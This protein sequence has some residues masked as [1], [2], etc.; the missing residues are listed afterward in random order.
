MVFDVFGTLVD[1]RRSIAREAQ[2]VL[3]LP[4]IA[5]D[6]LAAAEVFDLA[7]AQRMMVAAH[8]A[9]LAAAAA[10]GL[11]TAFVARPDE[12]GA[13]KGE[14]QPACA[15]DLAVSGPVEPAAALAPCP[16]SRAARRPTC[17]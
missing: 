17:K 15:A 8:S 13:V 16:A 6:R 7:P 5:I 11:R 3:A 10:I 9:D 2:I 4:G 14:V 12:S 1:W